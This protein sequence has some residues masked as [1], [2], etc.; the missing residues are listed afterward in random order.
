MILGFILQSGIELLC[1]MPRRQH[2]NWRARGGFREINKKRN[3][4]H[5]WILPWYLGRVE[6]KETLVLFVF[7]FIDTKWSK[8]MNI[9]SFSIL[10]CTLSF[11]WRMSD[12]AAT[13]VSFHNLKHDW[14]S[15]PACAFEDY[16]PRIEAVVLFG[17]PVRW[18]T[19]LQ[20]IIDVLLV[21]Y[22]IKHVLSL[23]ISVS[24]ST[25]C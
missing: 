22:D 8:M 7:N 3:S 11:H 23:L 24:G 6:M 15:A 21:S 4:F 13:L 2:R 16:F 9:F 17:E 14:F 25:S 10:V 1:W 5:N 19:P 12:N 18:E 20:L